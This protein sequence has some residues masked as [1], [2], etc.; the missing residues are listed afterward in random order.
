MQKPD[1]AAIAKLLSDQKKLLGETVYHLTLALH[2]ATLAL[3]HDI[4]VDKIED[5]LCA[6]RDAH[7]QHK[8]ALEEC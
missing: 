8:E 5:A 6:A 2:G 3:D 4:P 7:E 1:N